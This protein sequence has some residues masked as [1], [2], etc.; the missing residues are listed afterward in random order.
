MT[1]RKD[2]DKTIVLDSHAK[3]DSLKQDLA[4]ELPYDLVF[5]LLGNHIHIVLDNRNI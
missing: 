1:E 2:K 5:F 3:R 4:S